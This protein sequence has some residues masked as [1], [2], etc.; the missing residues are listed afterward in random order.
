MCKWLTHRN[1]EF[2][3][4]ELFSDH[5]YCVDGNAIS[6][7]FT[8]NSKVAYIDNTVANPFVTPEERD[9]AMKILYDKLEDD[10]LKMGF[11]VIIRYS[12]FPTMK[13]RL[14]DRGFF[15]DGQY[16]RFIKVIRRR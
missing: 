6:F 11:M 1:M 3:P 8:T 10:A 4:K 16:E 15:V 7:L 5:G 13:K 9:V 2:Q 14:L 12:N